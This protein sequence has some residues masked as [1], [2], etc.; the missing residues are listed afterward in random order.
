[1]P[2][3]SPTEVNWVYTHLYSHLSSLFQSLIITCRLGYA[4]SS[5]V[6]DVK[7]RVACEISSGDELL[8]TELLFNGVFNDLTAEQCAAL[9]C[10]FVFQEKVCV[11]VSFSPALIVP[12]VTHGCLLAVRVHAQA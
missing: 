12:T 3:T 6:I 5:D 11:C 4:S 8:L 2:K 1:M 7:G 10:C 9:L